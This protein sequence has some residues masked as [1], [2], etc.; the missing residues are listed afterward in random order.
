[1]TQRLPKGAD[2]QE[3]A[4]QRLDEAAA[5]GELEVRSAW[6]GRPLDLSDANDPDWWIK[7]R[8]R[9][10]QL[11]ALPPALQLRR[12]RDELL[13]GLDAMH[14]EVH[15]REVLEKL[16][17]RIRYAL[18]HAIPGPPSTLMP[19]DVEALV[20]QWRA[21][22]PPP[23]PRVEPPPRRRWWQRLLRRGARSIA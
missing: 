17:A 3:V 13:A 15:V 19:L 18:G 12:D 21:R 23:V 6:H 16:D 2:P 5:R 14:S 8:L 22:R 4:E 7:R 10:E 9:E 20:E 1:M 11:V